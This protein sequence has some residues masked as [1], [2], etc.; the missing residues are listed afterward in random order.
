M[1]YSSYILSFCLTIFYNLTLSLSREK[2]LYVQHHTA[3][4]FVGKSYFKCSNLILSFYNFIPH[5]NFSNV[6]VQNMSLNVIVHTNIKYLGFHLKP[7]MYS[8]RNVG[9]KAIFFWETRRK[10]AWFA[11]VIQDVDTVKL[12]EFSFLWKYLFK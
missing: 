5:P 6:P 3:F 1:Q 4:S 10:L 9:T 12:D 7:D 2:F 11:S 8:Y